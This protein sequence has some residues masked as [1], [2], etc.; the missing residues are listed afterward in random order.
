[1]KKLILSVAIL[2]VAA[3]CSKNEMTELA[4][5]LQNEIGFSTLNDRV[6]SKAANDDDDDFRLFAHMQNSTVNEWFIKD[7]VEH[8]SDIDEKAYAPVGGP[9]YWPADGIYSDIVFYAYAPYFTTGGN[10]V[11]TTAKVDTSTTTDITLTYTV[12]ATADEDFTVAAPVTATYDADDDKVYEDAEGASVEDDV[13]LVFSHMLSKVTFKVQLDDGVDGSMVN[14]YISYDDDTENAY[15]EDGDDTTEYNEND[16]LP[17][18]DFTVAYNQIVVDADA[19]VPTVTNNTATTV[20]AEQTGDPTTSTYSGATTYMIA[21]QDAANCEI[22]I[23]GISI[24]IKNIHN[25]IFGDENSANLAPITLVGSEVKTED[26]NI[27]NTMTNT[28]AYA[29][30]PGY[31]YTFTITIYNTSDDEEE[32]PILGAEIVATANVADWNTPNNV[33]LDQGDITE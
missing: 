18:I 26:T 22:Q 6:V 19:T 5:S 29:F 32:D 15:S 30:L 3:S 14:Y 17:T 28:E 27:P 10:V 23:K 9:Y 7:Y 24:R 16:V 25:S 4:P 1:M 11:E 13:P 8:A 12:P 2:A 21:P 31:H 20:T 33:T